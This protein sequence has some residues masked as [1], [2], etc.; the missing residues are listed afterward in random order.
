MYVELRSVPR[1]IGLRIASLTENYLQCTNYI[2]I[3]VSTHLFKREKAMGCLSKYFTS[4]VQ[5]RNY[6]SLI[7]PISLIGLNEI[8]FLIKCMLSNLF[9]VYDTFITYSQLAK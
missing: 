1:G 5:K 6:S 9:T 2:V 4:L 3:C 7:T 8:H